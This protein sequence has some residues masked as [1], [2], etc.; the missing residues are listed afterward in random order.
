MVDI[1]NIQVSE[2]SV[3]E[4]VTLA[5]VKTW[6]TIDFGDMDAI[7]VTMIKGARKSIESLLNLALVPKQIT[8]DVTVTKCSELVTL[9]YCKGV[10]AVTV[11]E[12]DPQDQTTALAN[13]VDYY[14]RGNGLRISEG[15][16]SVAYTT[17]LAII[18]EDLKEAIKMEVAERYLSRGENAA[19]KG[20]VEVGLSRAAMIKAL[21]YQINWL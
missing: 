9:P 5:E 13:G 2:G 1:S 4:P 18:P 7:L 12:L 17:V 11:N 15:R 8:L 21:P 6:L 19:S 20:A 14:V 3:T 16:Y 10:T